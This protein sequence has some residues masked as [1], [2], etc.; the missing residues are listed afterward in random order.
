M[1]DVSP[2]S[3]NA[4]DDQPHDVPQGEGEA[5]VEVIKTPHQ[6]RAWGTAATVYVPKVSTPLDDGTETSPIPKV[7]LWAM[8]FHRRVKFGHHADP[9]GQ[10]VIGQGNT[11]IFAIDPVTKHATIGRLVGTGPDG[12][13]Y[14]LVAS[15]EPD[16]I[17]SLVAGRHPT[18]WG[19]KQSKQA[20]LCAV[21]DGGDGVSNVSDVENYGQGGNVPV[22]F[23]PPQP[24]V[25]FEEPIYGS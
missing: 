6:R 14:C 24:F 8:K 23:L 1:T 10:Q 2:T 22:Q 13:V 21:F 12:C 15:A 25:E 4:P 11:Q 5:E 16:V 19:F 17:N 20:R 3:E 7:L 9:I 18:S